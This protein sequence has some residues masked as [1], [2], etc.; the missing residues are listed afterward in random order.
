MYNI[1]KFKQL[2]QTT[3]CDLQ[4]LYSIYLF[5]FKTFKLM[6]FFLSKVS[7]KKNQKQ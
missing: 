3:Q 7:E 2:I 1:S 5:I 6:A 4:I